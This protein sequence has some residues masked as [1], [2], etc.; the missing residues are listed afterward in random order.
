MTLP[1]LKT[2]GISDDDVIWEREAQRLTAD[3]VSV[4]LDTVAAIN[5]LSSVE[6]IDIKRVHD[7]ISDEIPRFDQWDQKISEARNS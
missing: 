1:A 7:F 4:I 6:K 5:K 2:F 3:L